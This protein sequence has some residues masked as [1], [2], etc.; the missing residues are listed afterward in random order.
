MARKQHEEQIADILF[1]HERPN[2]NEEPDTTEALQDSEKV[3]AI[4][5]ELQGMCTTTQTGWWSYKVCHMG[6]VTQFH[7]PEDESMTRVDL[8][9]G[10][11]L[12]ASSQL[13]R[14]QHTRTWLPVH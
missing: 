12:V 9:L 8:S 5:R 11:V 2:E 7:D 3:L 10:R 4:M 1:G 14:F 6:D 13:G